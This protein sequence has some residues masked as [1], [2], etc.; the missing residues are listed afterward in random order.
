MVARFAGSG[1]TATRLPGLI[2]IEGK[3]SNISCGMHNMQD[4][5][6]VA[7]NPKIDVV[8]AMNGKPQPGPDR[9]AWHAGMAG[10]GYAMKM[11]DNF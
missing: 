5:G 11:V 10:L 4:D 1:K 2:V 6:L 8:P 7:G 9:I 3:S